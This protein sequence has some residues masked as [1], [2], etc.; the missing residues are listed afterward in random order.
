ML[1][2]L[3]HFNIFRTVKADR[4]RKRSLDEARSQLIDA[5]ANK[6]YYD[7]IVPMLRKR[8]YRLEQEIAKAARVTR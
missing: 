2:F 1:G 3:N 6:E 7:A 5:V 8:I 4:R